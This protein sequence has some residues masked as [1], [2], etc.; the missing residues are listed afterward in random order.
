[1]RY[2]VQGSTELARDQIEEI[3]DHGDEDSEAVATLR[4]DLSEILSKED[5]SPFRLCKSTYL[6]A[7]QGVT[8][9]RRWEY[10]FDNLYGPTPSTSPRYFCEVSELLEYETA[11]G[12]LTEESLIQ[13]K[14]SEAGVEVLEIIPLP[15]G[16]GT[17]LE[18][19][20][21]LEMGGPEV[22]Y[23]RWNDYSGEM[24]WIK[25]GS[26]SSEYTLLKKDVDGD[27][28]EN[29]SI[30][31]RPSY[32]Y[33]ACPTLTE[34]VTAI[35]FFPYDKNDYF[36]VPI[37]EQTC[38]PRLDNL[39]DLLD[40]DDGDGVADWISD[41]YDISQAFNPDYEGPDYAT[42]TD[43]VGIVFP[44]GLPGD[45]LS[46]MNNMA[47]FIEFFWETEDPTSLRP[48]IE[49]LIAVYEGRPY[50]EYPITNLRYLLARTYELEGNTCVAIQYYLD[51]A[52][53]DPPTLWSQLAAAHLQPGDGGADSCP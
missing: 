42:Y 23:Y 38:Q 8:I 6:P 9:S 27:G 18:W 25:V 15:Q 36:H 47:D 19:I 16:A 14:L 49:A 4:T 28:L 32:V 5:I 29:V 22:Y 37:N 10:Y 52:Q 51:V 45:G 40:D 41:Y 20:L 1:M 50:S 24:Q 17:P 35:V 12:L 53:N 31:F 44:D 43:I 48:V 34:A 21:I 3:L 30:L 13:H 7:S 46:E 11:K 39:A 26:I 33:R 2:S